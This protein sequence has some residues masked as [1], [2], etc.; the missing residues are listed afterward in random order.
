MGEKK[1]RRKKS[2]VGRKN[3]KNRAYR[4]GRFRESHAMNP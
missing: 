2:R 1:K 3:G 4:V